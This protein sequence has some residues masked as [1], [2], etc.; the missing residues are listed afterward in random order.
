MTDAEPDTDVLLD[1]VDRGDPVAR[2]ELLQRHRRRLRR[3]LDVR[4][5]RRLVTRLDPSDLVQQTLADADR[6]LDDYLRD[7][8]LPFYPWLRQLAADRLADE[9]RRHVRAARRAVGREETFVP[10]LP[11]ASALELAGRLFAAGPGPSEAAR[12]AEVRDRVR[13]ALDALSDRDREVVILR[14]LE[15]MTAGEVA[16]VL[17][18]TEPAVK[19]RALRAMRRLR[20]LLADDSTGAGHE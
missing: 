20:A 17:G 6:R 2:G 12:R 13:A 15:Q 4:M 7:R 8:P 10:P 19:S 9:Y 11:D 1:R 18:L 5:D 3:M 16:A 14:Y